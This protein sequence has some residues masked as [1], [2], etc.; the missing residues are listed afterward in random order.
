M[1]DVS[2][3]GS[4]IQLP[5]EVVY[6]EPVEDTAAEEVPGTGGGEMTPEEIE[7]SEGLGNHV[8]TTA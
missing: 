1:G 6:T 3:V 8:D 4:S 2:E 7:G 5:Q